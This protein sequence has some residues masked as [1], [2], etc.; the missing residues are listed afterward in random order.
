MEY[1]AHS[2][3]VAVLET[4]TFCEI[5]DMHWEGGFPLIFVIFLSFSF[6]FWDAH[7][8]TG[9]KFPLSQFKK[10]LINDCCFRGFL[11]VTWHLLRDSKEQEAG[12]KL[13]T[14]PFLPCCL[15]FYCPSPIFSRVSKGNG[16]LC[17]CSAHLVYQSLPNHSKQAGFSQVSVWS[18]LLLEPS[19]FCGNN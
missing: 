9:S 1:G 18:K 6:S 2:C 8:C 12:Q 3:S 11:K 16:E 10:C 15:V 7:N 19:M 4:E 17:D 5:Q 14:D 13:L